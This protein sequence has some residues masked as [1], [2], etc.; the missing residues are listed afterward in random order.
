M[1]LINIPSMQE[2]VREIVIGENEPCWFHGEPGCGKSEGMNAAVEAEDAQ[3]ID[4]RLGQYDTVD[5]RG[6]PDVDRTNNTTVWYMASTLPF[7]GNP[8]FDP[9]QKKVIFFDEAD[10]G[11]EAVQGI[12]YQLM[13]ERRVGEHHLQPNTFICSAGNRKADKGVGGRS[14]KP[15]NNRNTHFEVGPDAKVW[16]NWGLKQERIPGELIAFMHFREPLISN[17]DPKSPEPAFATPRTWEKVGKYLTNPKLSEGVRNAS[18]EGAVGVA[19]SAELIGFLKVI[20]K[21]PS[22]EDIERNPKGIDISSQPEVRWAVSVGIAGAMAARPESTPAFH[23]YLERLDPEFG[24][25]AWQ[26]GVRKN[27]ALIGTDQ[28]IAMAQKHQALF[29]AVNRG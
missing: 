22:I 16:C 6:Y 9:D 27:E 19:A 29:A 11:T 17:F 5:F 14:F 28:F 21:M 25:L 4:F 2:V 10:H 3:L 20:D 18:I 15:L 7:V 26:L 13:Q 24:I 12:C 8:K 1:H 23:Q